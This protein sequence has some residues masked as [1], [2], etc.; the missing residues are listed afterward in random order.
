[1]KPDK[2]DYLVFSKEFTKQEALPAESI[3]RAVEVMQSGRLHRYNTAAGE[4]SEVSL[5][6]AE[7]A[8]DASPAAVL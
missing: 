5:L 2:A 4:A 3:Q 6:E 7:F 1:M 8:S